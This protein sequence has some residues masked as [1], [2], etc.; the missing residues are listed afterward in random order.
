M[1][2][3]VRLAVLALALASAPPALAASPA[4]AADA[5]DCTQTSDSDVPQLTRQASRPLELLGIDQAQRLATGSGGL[6]GAGVTVAVVDSG[7]A[8]H[9]QVTLAG[10]QY[11]VST[12]TGPVRPLDYHGTAVAGLI[13]G[14]ARPDGRPVG[15]APG[16]RVVDVQVYGWAKGTSG[17]PSQPDRADLVA[18]LDRLARQARGLQVKVAVVPI[19]VTPDHSLAVAVRRLQAQGVLVVAPS[20]NRPDPSDTLSPLAAYA[21]DRPGQDGYP[22][23]GPAN[24]PG[25]LVAGTTAAGSTPAE[26]PG[27]IPNHA[28]DVVVP[29]AGGIS[30]ALNGGT[31]VLTEP[32][33]SWAAAEVGGIAARI[34]DTA[35]GTR[36]EGSDP[37]PGAETS[38]YFGAGVVQPVD[39]LTRPLTPA[40]GAFSSLRSSPDRT[41]PVRPPA[42]AGDVLQH[43][44]RTAIWAGLLGGAGI[45][46][47]SLL[48]PLLT[49]RTSR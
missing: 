25:V 40:G 6:P 31:C 20:G 24:V 28:V 27:S 39:A 1:T 26:N 13:A 32:A 34:I 3:R 44:R 41:P 11:S 36:G 18:G 33:T 2:A 42:E 19:A 21:T 4:Y 22:D 5:P 15:I 43:S 29:T 46:V 47:A 17:Q 30:L 23:I 14:H 10:P 45:V 49:R 16:A 38:R 48:R 7:I 12:G 9:D 8:P 37:G 35:S